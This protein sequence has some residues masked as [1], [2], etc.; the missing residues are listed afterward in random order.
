MNYFLLFGILPKR[1]KTWWKKDKEI[2][3]INPSKKQKVRQVMKRI[4]SFI[5]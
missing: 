2:I 5:G 1:Q 3:W 4:T